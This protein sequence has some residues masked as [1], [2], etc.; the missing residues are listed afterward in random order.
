M[1]QL[2]TVF[3]GANIFS[4]LD[5]RGAYNL[6]RIKE[7]DKYLTAFRTKFGSYEYLVM[8]FGLTNAPASFQNLVN[9]IFSDLLEIF[10]V[11]Y[12]D[13][14]LIYSKS[15]EEHIGHVTQVLHRLR[16]NNLYAK[17]SKCVFHT[18]TVDYLGYVVLSPEGLSMD[19]SKVA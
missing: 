9:D 4:K 17:A 16:N 10:V 14:I 19:Q 15:L 12:L 8:P 2:L 13:D 5:L 6:L 11:V 1:A 3:Q 18:N 7:G